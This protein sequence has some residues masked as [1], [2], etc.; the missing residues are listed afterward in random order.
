M[1]FEGKN[2]LPRPGVPQLQGS[3][4]TPRDDA[5]PIRADCHALHRPGVALEGDEFFPRLCVPH[6]YCVGQKPPTSTG[7]TF[8]VTAKR[9]VSPPPIIMDDTCTDNERIGT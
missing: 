4:P 8:T 5:G 9:H 6:L 3:I 7:D 1:S 2:F